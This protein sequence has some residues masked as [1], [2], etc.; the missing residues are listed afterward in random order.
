MRVYVV[1]WAAHDVDGQH[2]IHAFGKTADGQAAVVRVC[3]YPYFFVKRP[4][5]TS[6]PALKLFVHDCVREYRANESYSLPVWRKDAW[7]Y[8]DDVTK[9]HGEASSLLFVQL[10][11]DTLKDQRIARSRLA[12]A[13]AAT[14]EGTVDSVVRLCHVRKIAPTG[15]IEVDDRHFEEPETAMYPRADLELRGQFGSVHPVEDAPPPPGLVLCSWDLEVYSSTGAFP[16][17][18]VQDNAIIQVAC[19]FQRL[20]EPAPYRTV[21]VCLGETAPVE[22]V[23]IIAV[24]AEADLLDEWMRVMAE[25]R[26]D[27]LLGWNT[28]QF[29]WKYVA[30]RVG[31]LTDDFGTPAVDLAG[32]NGDCGLGRGPMGAGDTRAWELTSGAYGSN[33][34]LLLRCPGVLDL[35]LMQLVKREHKLASYALGTVSAHFLPGGETKLDLPPCEIFRK[36]AEGDADDRA[37]IARYAVQDVLLPLK[38]FGVLRMYD[39]LAQMSVATCVPVDYLLS[40]GQQIKVFSLILRQA[41]VMGYVLPDDK[42]IT[43]EGKFEGATVLEAKKG[44]YFDV[45]SGLDFM[46]LYPSIIRSYN[47]CYSTLLLPGSPEPPADQVY[48]VETAL[49][50]FRFAQDI[51]GIVPELLKNLAVWRKDAKTKMAACKAAGDPFGAGVW[52]GLQLAFKV[53]ANSVYGFMG[54]SQ[55]FLPCVPI[56]ASVTATGT[57]L[58]VYRLPPRRAEHEHVLIQLLAPQ[59]V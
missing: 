32:T 7:G 59:V 43:I 19:A 58:C 15:W 25:E 54:A 41:R 38:L 44:A 27:V 26:V 17:P 1:E 53:S 22:G 29:D 28:W 50:T 55:G 13:G 57:F 34:Y 16:V 46:S 9:K 48:A 12:K 11:F 5:G 49:G 2:E 14:Y 37:D 8:G 21:V 10:A 18:E 4:V 36:W 23:D 52:D 39:N 24:G 31:V 40:R 56:A 35:D 30:G 33:S 42:S 47:M 3:F 6:V 45:I 20:G 51:P